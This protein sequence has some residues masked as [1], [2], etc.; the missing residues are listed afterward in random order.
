MYFSKNK[1]K[2]DRII[3]PLNTCTNRESNPG[4]KFGKLLS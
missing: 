3:V 1:K 4:L 2:F